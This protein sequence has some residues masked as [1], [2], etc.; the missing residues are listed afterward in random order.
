MQ[1]CEAAVL[2]LI[3]PY[4]NVELADDVRRLFREIEGGLATGCPRPIGE[5]TPE[6]DALENAE[7]YEIRVDLAGVSGSSL[8]VLLKS[9]ALIIAGEK[10]PGQTAPDGARFHLI[11]RSFGR[12]ARVVRLTSAIDGARATATLVNGELRVIVPKIAERR[13][14]ELSIPIGT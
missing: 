11:E 1:G 6:L 13:G 10:L 9:G 2:D 4:S 8:R 7:A 12:F 3:L 14:R 5:C